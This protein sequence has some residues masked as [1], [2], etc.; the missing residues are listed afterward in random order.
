LNVSS[1]NYLPA[2]KID[3]PMIVWNIAKIKQQLKWSLQGIWLRGCTRYGND[4]M[5]RMKGHVINLVLVKTC[6]F[7]C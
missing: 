2:G 3:A 4:V 6:I 5:L 7:V 1:V